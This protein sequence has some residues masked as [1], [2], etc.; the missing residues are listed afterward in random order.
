MI[1]LPIT[2]AR[3]TYTL[4]QRGT[5]FLETTCGATTETVAEFGKIYRLENDDE[6]T[7][8]NDMGPTGLV[9]LRIV[10]S[11]DGGKRSLSHGRTQLLGCIEKGSGCL[12]TLSL[13]S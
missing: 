7:I 13:L 4:P 1:E 5:S 12:R 10:G 6:T 9:E 3:S 11:G 8:E 2:R